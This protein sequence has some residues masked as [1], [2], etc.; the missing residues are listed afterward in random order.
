MDG[1]LL[2]CFVLQVLYAR[3][4]SLKPFLQHGTIW[5]MFFFYFL[6]FFF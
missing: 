2:Y 6:F 5:E 3:G 1:R 4:G